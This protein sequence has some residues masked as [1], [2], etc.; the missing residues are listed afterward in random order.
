MKRIWDLMVE[1]CL[2][3]EAGDMTA[4]QAADLPQTT[5]RDSA[6]VPEALGYKDPDNQWVNPSVLDLAKFMRWGISSGPGSVKELTS[7][8]LR[9]SVRQGIRRQKVV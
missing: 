1:T 7:G 6:L 2:K 5:V 8:L 4:Q 9:A 3:Y